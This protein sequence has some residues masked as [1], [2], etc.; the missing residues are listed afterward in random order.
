VKFFFFYRLNTLFW[1]LSVINQ[2]FAFVY[3]D[4]VANAAPVDWQ[5][6]VVGCLFDDM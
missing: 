3:P 4:A 1:V 5:V 2:Q 6:V